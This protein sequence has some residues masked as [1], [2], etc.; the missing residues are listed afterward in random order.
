MPFLSRIPYLV[1]FDT[2]SDIWRNKPTV[3]FHTPFCFDILL[4]AT[5]CHS[6]HIPFCFDILLS[7]TECHKYTYTFV[8]NG[9]PYD[10]PF[11]FDIL[12]SATDCHTIRSD[13]PCYSLNKYKTAAWNLI[14]IMETAEFAF[15]FAFPFELAE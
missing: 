11:W 9:M 8:R 14:S 5:E 4:S 10:T 7:A 1:T 6:F 3:C 12:L 2:T 15:P 13:H